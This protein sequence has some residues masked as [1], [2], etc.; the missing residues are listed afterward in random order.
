M[1]QYL[2]NNLCC[3]SIMATHLCVC[4]EKYIAVPLNEKGNVAVWKTQTNQ[5]KVITL[6]I[7]NFSNIYT[8]VSFI[9]SRA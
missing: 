9:I 1:A 5:D 4:S 6:C 2:I 7:F 3:P 8:V